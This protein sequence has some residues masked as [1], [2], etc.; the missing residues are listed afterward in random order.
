MKSS[1]VGSTPNFSCFLSFLGPVLRDSQNQVTSFLGPQNRFFSPSPFVS[2]FAFGL[3]FVFFLRALYVL[4]HLQFSIDLAQTGKLFD[5]SM[6]QDFFFPLFGS[7]KIA[8]YASSEKGGQRRG[9]RLPEIPYTWDDL[10]KWFTP[11][12]SAMEETLFGA[13]QI[14]FETDFS[15]MLDWIKQKNLSEPPLLNRTRGSSRDPG[16]FSQF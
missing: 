6:N 2:F 7:D 16:L 1:Q 10:Q 4:Q 8:K 3:T 15:K 12:F 5:L 9:R 14:P 13:C 11:L